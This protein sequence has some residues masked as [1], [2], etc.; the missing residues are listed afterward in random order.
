[1][2][3]IRELPLAAS[4]LVI[5][6][7]L[8]FG[9]GASSGSLPWLGAAVLIALLALAGDARRAR[10][11]AGGRAARAPRPLARAD[12]LVVRAA[13]TLLG[14][15]E[16]RAALHALRRARALARSAQAGARARA[17]GAP[18]RGRRLV[19][20]RQ[21]RC[22]RSTTTTGASRGSAARSAYWNQLALLGDFALAL[23]LWHKRRA[24]TLLA[25]GWLV[26][27]A[28]TYSRG[29]LVTAVFVVAAWLVLSDERIESAA[30]LVAAALPAAV[31]VGIAF[32]ATRRH[33]R[34]RDDVDALARRA[35]LRRARRRRCLRCSRALTRTASARHARAP[36]CP[37][38]RRSRRASSRSW[39]AASSPPARSRARARSRAAPVATRAPARTSAG[40][41]GSRPGTG[42]QDTG[43]PGR[44]PAR[45]TSRTSATAARS[46]T[47]RPSRTACRCSSSRRPASS[48]SCCCSSRSSRSLRPGWRRRGHE[49]ALALFLPAYLLHSLIDVDWD[50][51]A[52]AAPA[53]VA[54]G[55]LA[56]RPA[57]PAGAAARAARRHGCGAVRVR[58]PA[59]AVA[60]RALVGRGARRLAGA[61][62]AARRPRALGRPAARRPALGEGLRRRD[63]R[64]AAARVPATT[65]RPSTASRRTRRPGGSPASTRSSLRLLSQRVHLSREVHGAR[66][67]EGG[68]ARARTTTARRCGR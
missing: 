27:L 41:G 42:G 3:A 30:T 11:L 40:S 22:R 49:L 15:R 58:R 59:P 24:G 34:R 16:P 36:A 23:A 48:G 62:G 56:G 33:E 14:V 32:A 35:D 10:R 13:R 64:R 31:V 20:P 9:G 6:A 39:S 28:L 60:R 38:R 26:A 53:F 67:A 21:G 25:Y 5:G 18:R 55:A 52:V 51:V 29:G 37:L 47:R 43:W 46:S 7:A 61:S 50:F 57:L 54:A 8:F 4:L 68:R 66:P 63:A 19:A 44:A 2:P 65:C 1:M 12:D 17:D 45:S